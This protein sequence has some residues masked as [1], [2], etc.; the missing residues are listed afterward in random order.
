M[1]SAE[2]VGKVGLQPL[3]L[4]DPLPTASESLSYIYLLDASPALLLFQPT[5]RLLFSPFNTS[6][7]LHST[8]SP[9][10]L[11]VND[12]NVVESI[13]KMSSNDNAAKGKSAV[14]HRSLHFEPLQVTS[15]RGNYLHLSNGQKIFD[16]TGGAAVSCLGHGDVRYALLYQPDSTLI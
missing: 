15:A 16:A 8:M 11:V 1:R 6:I 13:D 2:T 5:I 4:L 7:Q 14:L 10:V 12:G 9:S 3:P